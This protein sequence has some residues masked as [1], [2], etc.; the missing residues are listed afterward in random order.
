MVLEVT[1]TLIGF[2]SQRVDLFS[3][4]DVVEEVFLE[5]NLHILVA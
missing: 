3:L 1:I 5:P 4:Q 2:R